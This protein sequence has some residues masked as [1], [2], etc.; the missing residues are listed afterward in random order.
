MEYGDTAQTARRV[1]AEQDLAV[2][3]IRDA[4]LG[5]ETKG[6]LAEPPDETVND[7]VDLLMVLRS[8]ESDRDDEGASADDSD[9]EGASADD[10]DEA[11]MPAESGTA[12]GEERTAAET[13]NALA[14]GAGK[15]GTAAETVKALTAG[16]GEERTVAE[17]ANALAAGAGEEGTAAETVKALAAGAGK[18]GTAAETAHALAAGAGAA[19][20]GKAALAAGAVAGAGEAGT[21]AGAGAGAG[22]GAGAGAGAGTGTR[23]DSVI[24]NVKKGET[25]ISLG[26][27]DHQVCRVHFPDHNERII[28]WNMW[29]YGTSGGLNGKTETK[30][31]WKTRVVDQFS[32]INALRSKSYIVCLQEF[33]R[34]DY[35]M[36]TPDRPDVAAKMKTIIP[37]PV[38]GKFGCVTMA[39]NIIAREGGMLTDTIRNVVHRYRFSIHPNVAIAN[40]HLGSYPDKQRS[41]FVPKAISQINK[42]FD[43]FIQASG[44]QRPNLNV[45]IGDFNCD[46]SVIEKQIAGLA[47]VEKFVVLKNSSVTWDGTVSTPRTTDGCIVLRI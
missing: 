13:A 41:R 3:L 14:A 22:E 19:K 18:A 29:A 11:L 23:I 26:L 20:A 28:S 31:K 44:Q 43:N 25:A 37:D 7:V 12:A 24:I 46:L 15:E 36:D 45:M 8:D 35:D 21:A 39:G 47:F 9:D 30:D 1:D 42:R 27:S 6:S 10:S 5:Y 16:A 38:D 17:T 34:Q 2:Q 32:L 40:V 33:S 4:V